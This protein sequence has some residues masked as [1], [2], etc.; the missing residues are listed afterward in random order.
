MG[1]LFFNLRLMQSSVLDS[2]EYCGKCLIPSLG[3]FVVM[4]KVGCGLLSG[5]RPE[6]K[7]QK[8]FSKYFTIV[9][10]GWLGGYPLGAAQAFA[11]AERDEDVTDI[12]SVSSC[13]GVGFVVG[14]VGGYLCQSLV[15]G[16]CLYLFQILATSYCFLCRKT[17]A[18]N[19]A[20]GKNTCDKINK[21]DVVQLFVSSVRDSVN[22]VLT[23]CAFS[24]VFSLVS[25]FLATILT[26]DF[27][28]EI[29]RTI[30]EFSSGAVMAWQYL[31]VPLSYFCIG[32]A[33]GFGGLSVHAQILA[34]ADGHIVRYWSFLLFKLMIGMLCGAYSVLFFVRRWLGVFL[35]F[36]LAALIALVF[37]KYVSLFK[38]KKQKKC[39]RNTKIMI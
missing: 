27:S 16:T 14:A 32:F 31:P 3:P 19:C 17:N 35:L 18:E 13:A 5:Y 20:L 8:G 23:I 34:L 28:N 33:V 11:L 4:T 2:L 39:R 37:L 24:I 1:F 25:D 21:R 29:I 10:L 7:L 30:F 6:N 26:F 38:V 36:A 9:I 15:F 12:V 22:V